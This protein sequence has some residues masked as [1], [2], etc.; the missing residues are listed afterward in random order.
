MQGHLILF[1][2]FHLLMQT[3]VELFTHSDVDLPQL[4]TSCNKL[5]DLAMLSD[6][7]QQ[8]YA[9]MWYLACHYLPANHLH[10]V[11]VQSHICFACC[12]YFD[13]LCSHADDIS[14]S[15]NRCVTA[16]KQI[17]QHTR[18]A[19]AIALHLLELANIIG[20]IDFTS[21]FMA[22]TFYSV[23]AGDKAVVLQCLAVN[24][25]ASCEEAFTT[26]NGIVNS[27]K[28]SLSVAA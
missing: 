27:I 3:F 28:L 12:L 5:A 15:K 10:S 6:S 13:I 22:L 26:R 19:Q 20:I 17:T 24:S 25:G 21:V 1:S 14:S 16:D 9:G 23:Y 18:K 8:E 4:P 7:Q 11:D 2:A